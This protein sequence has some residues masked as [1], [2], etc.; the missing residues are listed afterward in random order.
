MVREMVEMIMKERG[1]SVY[2]AL[3][4]FCDIRDKLRGEIV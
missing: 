1:C 2:M 3:L 4:I